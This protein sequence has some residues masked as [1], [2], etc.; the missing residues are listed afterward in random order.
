[1]LMVEGAPA[2]YSE[3]QVL[4]EQRRIV[5][6][7]AL[8]HRLDLR[9]RPIFPADEAVGLVRKNQPSTGH[10]PAEAAGATEPLGLGQVGLASTERFFGPL[11]CFVLALQI[12]VQANVV[13]GHG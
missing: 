1:M 11:A 13:E 2:P 7:D 12:G 5:W 6:M 4:A 10:L 9:R 8:H 3:L